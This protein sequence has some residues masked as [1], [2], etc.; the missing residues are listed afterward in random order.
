MRLIL[1]DD[2]SWENL[3]PLTFTR[4]AAALRVGIW[5]IAEKWAHRLGTEPS[6]LAPVYLS[7]KFPM[8]TG[9]DNLFINGSLLPD[10][11]LTGAVRSI[12]TGEALYSQGR[13]LAFRVDKK[14]A[15]AIEPPVWTSR[16]MEKVPGE[17][18]NWIIRKREYEG[19]VSIVDYPWKIFSLN[20]QEIE[21]DFDGLTAGR[22]GITI[23]DSIRVT[24]SGRIFAEPGFKGEHIT[25]NTSA[26]SIY[27]GRDAEI[28]EGS[29][30]RG[31]FALCEGAVL[32]LGTRIYGP[33]TIGPHCKA[34]GEINNS[35][36][37]ASSNKSH[38]GFLGNSVLGEWCNLG[39][40]TNN[41]NLKNNYGE[42][43]IWN[44]RAGQNIGTG[45]Q[46]CGMFMG[47]HSKSG[48]NTMFN[49]GTV[50]GVSANIFGP[51]FPDTFIPS[52]SWGGNEVTTYRLDKALETASRM[53]ER[54][55]VPLS[56][57]DRDILEYVFGQT[58][59][60]RSY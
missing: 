18:E 7:K 3:L 60:L 19:T 46:F 45:L 30:V 22:T 9:E 47:D 33:T 50:V 26:G 35:V 32:K 40:D 23:S 31:P 12:E 17:T 6:F 20:G 29:A 34:G 27:L 24:G 5:T 56:D 10:D 59:K 48:I 28:M 15:D 21:A 39:A 58:E 49:T 51:G 14:T 36:L 11:G 4:P 41:S 25:L 44:Y 8:A 57:E 55:D 38:D 16:G 2:H 53:M 42:V 13:L 52:F 37:L 54:R 43:R 1:F